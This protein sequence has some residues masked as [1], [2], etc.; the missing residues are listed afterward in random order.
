MRKSLQ[1]IVGA[2]SSAGRKSINQDF[3]GSRIPE[4]PLLTSKGIAIALAD[5]ISSSKVSQEAST[6]SV[7]SFLEDYFCTPET[8]SVKNSALRVLQATNSWLFAQTRYSP[9]RFDRERGYICTFSGLILKSTTAHVFHAGDARVYKLQG[10]QLEQLTQDHRHYESAESSYLTRALGIHQT[11][12]LDYLSLPVESG[13]TFVLA[14]DGVYEFIPAEAIVA[15]LQQ[16]GD[17]LERAAAAIID[18]ALDSGSDDNLTVQLLRVKQLPERNLQELQQ[19][20]LNLP[21][22]PQ[23]R[24]RM[25]FE[26]YLITRELYIS[27]RS[28]V[29]LARD[30]E[31]GEQVVIKTPSREMSADQTYLEHFLM[32]EWI[33]RRL[34]N[35]HVLKAPPLAR[36]RKSLYLVTE[37]VEG[38]T[39]AQWIIDNPQAPLESVRSIISQIAKGLQA[40]HRQEMLH[41]DLRPNNIMIDAGGTVKIIDFGA[42]HVAGLAELQ[43]EA[44]Q[45]VPG[46]AQ[47]TA[48]EYYLGESGTPAS[49]VYSLAVIA[50]QMLSGQFPYGSNVARTRSRA[51]Q[52]KLSY[53]SVMTDDLQVPLWVDEALKKATAVDPRRRYREVSEFVHDL[54]KPS[55]AFSS[56]HRP[57]L[58]ERNP[59]QFWQWVS[60]ILLVIVILQAAYH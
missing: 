23:L 54:H 7:R 2:H 14:T 3:H 60:F 45:Q 46:T 12:E 43:P 18:R 48:P 59:V 41:Q 25:E 32:E 50:Y 30:L 51:A 47:Y 57:P 26:G 19:Q 49:D 22:P 33:A 17:D 36:Q 13:D 55:A 37:F 34:N 20:S 39:L 58:L 21:L 1:V 11:V 53:H 15:L 40:F 24:P 28:H 9:H 52:N 5:G 8:W 27:S 42:V 6:A 4:E 31:S 56:R 35:P 10:D 29:F 16:Y 38:Q 44:P